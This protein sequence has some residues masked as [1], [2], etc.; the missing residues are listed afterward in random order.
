MDEVNRLI[1]EDNLVEHMEVDSI[2]LWKTMK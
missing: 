1:L 2:S